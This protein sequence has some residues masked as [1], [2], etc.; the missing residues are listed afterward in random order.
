MSQPGYTTTPALLLSFLSSQASACLTGLRYV[1]PTSRCQPCQARFGFGLNCCPAPATTNPAPGPPT[2]TNA[3][4]CGLK[5]AD[6][7]VGGEAAAENEFPWMCAV[8]NSDNSFFT[9]GAT[10]LS[11]DPLIVVTAAHCFPS[12]Q[13]GGAKL[14]CGAHTLKQV[15]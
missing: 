9:C 8:L 4:R 13:P 15:T 5:G 3:T 6:R 1:P 7:I 2:L 14:A 12:G 11:C 10:L